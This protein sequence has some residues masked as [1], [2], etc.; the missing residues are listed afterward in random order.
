MM[1]SKRDIIFLLRGAIFRFQPL[2][3]FF[4]GVGDSLDAVSIGGLD[5]GKQMGGPSFFHEDITRTWEFGVICFLKMIFAPH[6][7]GPRMMCSFFRGGFGR[8]VGN[9]CFKI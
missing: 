3:K 2:N 4:F 1:I 7:E 8:N 5:G 9:T 6:E